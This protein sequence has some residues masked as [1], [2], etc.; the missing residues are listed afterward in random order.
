MAK[1][2]QLLKLQEIV[3][4]NPEYFNALKAGTADLSAPSAAHKDIVSHLSSMA[5]SIADEKKALPT[6]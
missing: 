5:S 3:N 1:A 2:N 4:Q 6:P